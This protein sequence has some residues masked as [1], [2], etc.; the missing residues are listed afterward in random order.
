[1]D[2]NDGQPDRRTKPQPR[3]SWCG[4]GLFDGP[5]LFARLERIGMSDRFNLIVRGMQRGDPMTLADAREF[6]MRCLLQGTPDRA[7]MAN[8]PSRERPAHTFELD[9]FNANRGRTRKA[10]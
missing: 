9:W 8:R 4:L 2:R 3:P 7:V 1:M 10:A 6:A 5:K